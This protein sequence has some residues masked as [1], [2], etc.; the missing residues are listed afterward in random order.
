M[1]EGVLP[2]QAPQGHLS[3][4]EVSGEQDSDLLDT[5]ISLIS[6]PVTANRGGVVRSSPP[7]TY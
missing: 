6:A 1:E 5:Q 3:R 2:V 7:T 4:E